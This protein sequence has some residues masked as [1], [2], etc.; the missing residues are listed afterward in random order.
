MTTLTDYVGEPSSNGFTLDDHHTENGNQENTMPG[1]NKIV[2]N[3][4]VDFPSLPLH[5]G[6][7]TSATATVG[8]VSKSSTLKPSVKSSTV[9]KRV[10]L[11]ANERA[12]KLTDAENELQSV[13]ESKTCKKIASATNTLIELSEA[14]DGSLCIMVSGKAPNV[15][16]AHCRLI[17]ELQTQ[18]VMTLKIP[19]EHYGAII[20]T[21]GASLRKLENEFFCRIN[22]PKEDEGNIRITG[23]RVHV[24]RC[25]ERIYDISKERSKT[26]SEDLEIPR[27]FYP[28]IRGPF[29][30]NVDRWTA[31]GTVKVNIP[32]V[33]VNSES[34]NVNGDR[35]GVMKV[36]DE[37]KRI[38]REKLEKVRTLSTKVPSCQ[39]RFIVGNKG[40]GIQEIL[41]TTDCAIEIPTDDSENG[42]VILHGDQDRIVDALSM[43]YARAASIICKEI[44]C[45]QW[46]H[47][48][49]IGSKGSNLQT[50]FPDRV[51]LKIEFNDNGTVYIEA[52]QAEFQTSFATLE[53]EIN[54]IKNE[55]D[56]QVVVIPAEFH[57]HLVGKGGANI[58]KLRDE[59]EVSIIMPPEDTHSLDIFIDG[60]KEGVKKCVQHIKDLVSRMENEK[61]RDI[62]IEHRFHKKII[63]NK[64]E[65]INK[66][67]QQYPSVNLYF[68]DA[69]ES[70]CDIIQIRG[71]KAEVDKVYTYLTKL[72]KE[73]IESNYQE[74]V[75]IFK[76]FLKH[77]IGKGGVTINKIREETNTQIDLPLESSSNGK[78]IVTG[79]K[80]NVQK[81]VE[82]LTKIQEEQANII[83]VDLPIPPK[84]QKRF[85]F[86]GR[87]LLADIENECGNVFFSIK[88]KSNKI[89]I[90]GP[91]VPVSN[92][93]KLVHDLLKTLNEQTE[94]VTIEADSSYHKF[95]IGR[96]GSKLKQIREQ[97]PTVRILFPEEK[98]EAANTIYLIGKNDEVTAVK[99]IL[100]ARINELKEI[101]DLTVS[102]PLEYHKHFLIRGS[103]V[104]KEIQSQNGNVQ[105][106]FPKINSNSTFV[107]IKGSEVCAESAKQRIL[108]IVDDL[109][110]QVSIQVIVP[111]R[112][113]RSILG[114][115]KNAY[116]EI[117]K[118]HNVVIKLPD[119]KLA[120]EYN[121]E[122]VCLGDIITISG[123]AENC[124][125]AKA[126]LLALVPVTKEII[127]P[128]EFHS[129]LIGKGG[130][131]IRNLQQFYNV[132]VNVPYEN[133][134]SDVIKV[135]GLSDKVD[136]CLVDLKNRL[137][138]FEKIAADNI[139]KSFKLSVS[140]PVEYHQKLIGRKGVVVAGLRNK[141]NVQI[142][143]PK[144]ND[145]SDEI[146]IQGYEKN[147]NECKEDILSQVDQ[148][149]SMITMTIKLDPRYH[150]R[151]IG[152]GGR[153]L[154]K[155][156][157]DFNVDV[158]LPPKNAEDPSLVVIAG[159]NEDDVLNCIE[160]L[161][162]EEEDFI[163]LLI[164]RGQ[165][166][167]QREATP[168]QNIVKHS[169]QIV[170]A[171]W[172][173]NSSEQFPAIGIPTTVV[174][175]PIN[176]VWV[177]RVH[178]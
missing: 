33:N 169:V 44:P 173:V 58:S 81:A 37:I 49:L 103:E 112:H 9:S 130:K 53:A 137:E 148:W 166:T 119:R 57:R 61:T 127:I 113:L 79:K 118:E 126:A 91:K 142:T 40:S 110:A 25:A 41:K 66:I 34:I 163:D 115:Y 69:N 146:V 85:V 149:E 87:R 29:N 72:K 27:K 170:G 90:R 95:L 89:S 132:N 104:L 46:M 100:E 1:E 80:D 99:K 168:P 39:R 124:E 22:I 8:N 150:P 38:Y 174:T 54:R 135:V 144:D 123:R 131:D 158:R 6:T 129:A 133:D 42:T 21:K 23:P 31:D 106:F 164:E 93:E 165:Y 108:E 156:N 94:E 177:S 77:I 73:F 19:K 24:N 74:T 65:S 62:I 35:E 52:P 63:G 140:V 151:M 83:S 11:T 4:T 109:K 60:K 68:P 128:R 167:I 101:V 67:R 2:M 14:K 10:I 64:G 71:N 155:L 92:A 152:T 51:G 45:P 154:R 26:T 70:T 50:L 134:N 5:L 43:V 56:H 32:P 147:C 96:Q 141:H 13:E 20:G 120:E 55:M 171:P 114:A 160:H 30:E 47:R 76:E 105:I 18:V 78:V 162:I 175:P 139:L 3:Y 12:G 17:R 117:P 7:G 107:T 75:P 88:E 121:A 15:E 176:S 161:K 82:M 157:D 143:F 102:V 48:Y 136:E 125:K 84:A 98:S 153:A 138:E 172:Q 159:Y 178:K 97:Y 111:N 116:A 145:T 28:W 16:D 86:N 59:Y 122:G 36:V